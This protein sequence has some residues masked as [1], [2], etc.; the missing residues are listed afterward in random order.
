MVWVWA[1]ETQE[2]WS[3]FWLGESL[4]CQMFWLVFLEL[5]GREM[6]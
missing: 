1:R 3:S 6:V 4:M 2:E 5:K